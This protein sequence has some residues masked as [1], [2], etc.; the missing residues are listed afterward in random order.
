MTT[1]VVTYL[2]EVVL[3]TEV[4]DGYRNLVDVGQE[5]VHP[6]RR[7]KFSPFDQFDSLLNR[8]AVWQNHYWV[9]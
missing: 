4:F 1:L 6:G 2:I 3:S 9:S 7:R 8:F 5:T